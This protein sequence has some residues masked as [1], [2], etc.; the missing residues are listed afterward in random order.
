MSTT[1]KPAFDQQGELGDEARVDA[2]LSSF[3]REF[4]VTA[5][6]HL[7]SCVRC[8]LCAEACHFFLT[9][10]DPKYTPVYKLEPFRRA[11][12]REASPFAPLV[13]AL[14]LVRKPTIQDLEQWQEL[15]GA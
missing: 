3:L 4:G 12:F 11:Y 13:R 7:E 1:T 8:G 2:A 15:L 5:A 10:G 14:G 6:L 9:T